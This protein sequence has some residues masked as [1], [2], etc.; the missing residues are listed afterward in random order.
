[1]YQTENKKETIFTKEIKEKFS[2]I[3]IMTFI[4]IRDC[5]LQIIEFSNKKNSYLKMNEKNREF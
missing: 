4:N 3:K 5:C 2:I 1:M